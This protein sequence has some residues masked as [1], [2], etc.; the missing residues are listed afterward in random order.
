MKTKIFL[1][2]FLVIIMAL[3]VVTLSITPT[4]VSH[5]ETADLSGA[6]DTIIDATG[7]A[8]EDAITGT[9]EISD[10]SYYLALGDST[11]NGFGMSGLSLINSRKTYSYKLAQELGLNVNTQYKLLSND[12]FRY[13]DVRYILDD[14]YEPDAYSLDVVKRVESLRTTYTEEIAKADLI[15]VGYGFNNVYKFLFEQVLNV[16]GRT[17]LY[18]MN[19]LNLVG[20]EGL[21]Y[22]EQ[23]LTEINNSMLDNESIQS[24]ATSLGATSEDMTALVESFLYGYVGYSRNFYEVINKIHEINPEAEVVI[25]GLYNPLEGMTYE[26]MG[27]GEYINY[28]VSASDLQYT[29]GAML[30]PNTTFVSAGDVETILESK[31]TSGGNAESSF[32]SYLLNLLIN[33][34]K[35]LHASDVG[36][37]YIKDQ[38]LSAIT[39][40]KH[41]WADELYS[42]GTHHWIGC[43]NCDDVM[44]KEEHSFG[45]WTTVKEATET[46]DGSRERVCS[47]CDYT[48]VEHF[49]ITNFPGHEHYYEW[50]VTTR[51]TC[52]E[53]GEARGSC[54][55]GDTTTAT[56]P[57]LG[58]DVSAEWS[59]DTDNHWHAC[60][61]CDEL[62]GE[63]EHSYG[64]WTTVKEAT[65]T[66]EGEKQRACAC[67]YTQTQIVPAVGEPQVPDDPNTGGD[68]ESNGCDRC[69]G[70]VSV[71]F[72]VILFVGATL[73]ICVRIIRKRK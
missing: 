29:L 8:Y 40:T 61:G 3:S 25:V 73:I 59:Y 21:P 16:L 45:A 19:W 34:A 20:E 42:D 15:T 56:I 54:D 35:E 14:T 52:E 67:G 13:D 10:D 70:L 7:S 62:S 49:S 51:P 63:A 58:H 47:E 55:C 27:I 41:G 46:E 44:E 65:E 31:A 1:H 5:A 69:S 2:F 39:I 4:T 66:E 50:E 6:F 26:D 53:A 64:E 68:S 11:T 37:T 57:A 18:E 17:A 28:L 32:I 33:D 60:K 43:P 38:I 72:M 36:H 24:V 30:A 71:P 22:V 12:A 23:V 48:Q 9:Y